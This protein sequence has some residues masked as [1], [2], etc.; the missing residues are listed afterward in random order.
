MQCTAPFQ[1]LMCAVHASVL[2]CAHQCLCGSHGSSCWPSAQSGV[3]MGL[4]ELAQLNYARLIR[5][6]HLPELAHSS[7]RKEGS[8][9]FL[10]SL[11]WLSVRACVLLRAPVHSSLCVHLL[12]SHSHHRY[13]YVSTCAHR[14]TAAAAAAAGALPRPNWHACHAAA[15]QFRR[16][17]WRRPRRAT[18]RRQLEQDK[19]PHGS[20]TGPA[21]SQLQ[22][23]PQPPAGAG[24]FPH[25]VRSAR[26]LRHVWVRLLSGL[27]V[28]WLQLLLRAAARGALHSWHKCQD[29]LDEL[30][31]V[32]KG[33]G[34]MFC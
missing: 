23:R 2:E 12:V 31:I 7:S 30:A 33:K 29:R 9:V 15:Q 20:S 24:M 25:P 34:P 32:Q 4:V 28:R 22:Q 26:M 21:H 14:S 11:L 10:S 16:R 8:A 13:V 3:T 27:S 19:Q 1:A 18:Q 5:K 17:R 6:C